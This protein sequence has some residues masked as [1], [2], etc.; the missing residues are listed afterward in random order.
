MTQRFGWNGVVT[1]EFPGTH[2]G[3][4]SACIDCASQK[5]GLQGPSQTPAAYPLIVS[6]RNSI[7]EQLAPGSNRG[8]PEWQT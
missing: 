4:S 8:H 3:Y 6:P 7:S 1:L 2:N 5:L